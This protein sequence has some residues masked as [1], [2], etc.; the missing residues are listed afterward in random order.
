MG[1]LSQGVLK[2]VVFAIQ[3]CDKPWDRL[4]G[5]RVV[6][7]V[8]KAY[9]HAPAERQRPLNMVVRYSYTDP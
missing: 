5:W 7:A 1:F 9:E 6:D 4:K 8:I 3:P 2:T